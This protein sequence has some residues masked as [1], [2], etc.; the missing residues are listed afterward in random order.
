[1]RLSHKWLL[2]SLYVLEAMAISAMVVGIALVAFTRQTCPT[3]EAVFPFSMVVLG[4]LTT[5]LV[6]LEVIF[7]ID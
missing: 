2:R 3:S 5:S 1:M 4:S 6:G 7:L